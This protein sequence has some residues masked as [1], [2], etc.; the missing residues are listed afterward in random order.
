MAIR[1]A[2]EYL[3]EKGYIEDY[4][5]PLNLSL[6]SD[7]VL[8]D[9]KYCAEENQIKLDYTVRLYIDNI[10]GVPAFMDFDVLECD[11]KSRNHVDVTLEDAIKVLEL[12]N[13]IIDEE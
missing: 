13:S 4:D 2:F 10:Q 6:A 3:K 1:A 9:L 7:D 8:E 12:Q 5:I 11:F